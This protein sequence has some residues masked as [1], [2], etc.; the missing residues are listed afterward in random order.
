MEN[1]HIRINDLNQPPVLSPPL[2]IF[3]PVP[4]KGLVIYVDSSNPNYGAR[5]SIS[6]NV[7]ITITELNTFI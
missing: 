6:P 2:D 3:D 5:E 4:T 7:S 1:S